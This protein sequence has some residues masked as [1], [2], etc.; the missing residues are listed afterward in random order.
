MATSADIAFDGIIDTHIHLSEHYTGGL[1]N[2]WHPEQAESFRRNFTESEYL[3][4]ANSG[5]FRV[6]KAVFV[7]C[8]N[9][10]AIEEARWVLKM[11]E[12]PKSVISGMVA[13]IC[14]Q[15]GATA[16]NEFLEQLRDKDGKLPKGLKGAR[17]VFMARGEK[18]TPDACLDPT[19]LEG[20]KALEAA[21]LHW[22]FC[23]NPFM[24]PHLAKCC[25]QLPNMTF[26]IDHLAHNGGGDG[27]EM[28]KWGPAIDELGKLPNVYMK[29]GALEEWE[30]SDPE[31]YM[32]RAIKAFGFDRILFESNWFVQQA[33][34]DPFDRVAVMLLKCCRE[35]GATQEDLNKVFRENAAKV[36]RLDE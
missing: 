3:A 26:V 36:Y 8:F 22:E 20:L 34:G 15:D 24:A 13:Q 12:D 21:G 1:K 6:A 2:V 27:A 32:M 29:M 30:V 9:T 11:I 23:C 17:F 19:F 16:V 28:E 7:E 4:F 25:A 10:P 14:A 35:S 33:L 5:S 18:N 31:V